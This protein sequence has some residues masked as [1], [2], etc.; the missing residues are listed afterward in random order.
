MLLVVGTLNYDITM[1]VDHFAPPKSI[2]K[3]IERYLGGSGGNA[4]VAAARILGKGKVVLL[5]SVGNDDI[6]RKHVEELRREGVETRLIK[7]INGVET[8]QA[9]I[10]LKPDGENAIYSYRG[11]NSLLLPNLLSS[12][13]E[14]FIFSNVK[15]LLIMNPPIEMAKYL[16]SKLRNRVKFISWDPGAL[17]RLGLD[18]LKP[19][20][21]HTNYLLPNEDEL[22]AMTNTLRIDEAI[23]RLEEVNPDSVIIIKRGLKGSTIV[24]LVRG[25]SYS[26]SA[27]RPEDIGLRTISTVG[28]GDA[29][30]GVFSAALY[31][32]KDYIEAVKLATCAAT[33]NASRISPRGS[34]KIDY[35]LSIY[36]R[37]IGKIII[38][39][40]KI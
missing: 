7:V 8:G 14:E 27:V 19:V 35:L 18:G 28:C 9:Y 29:F 32:G 12:S 2:V 3:R 33:I 17:S 34:P 30:S 23:K 5:A 1:Y 20:I 36:D 15:A 22:L 25:E 4:A 11:A 31:M 38:K 24:D 40:V 21:A 16:V 13:D 37:C 6:G 10:A 26:V 39:G